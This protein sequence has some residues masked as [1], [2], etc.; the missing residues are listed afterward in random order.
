MG[1]KGH[2]QPR[3]PE[4]RTPS[5]SSALRAYLPTRMAA[6]EA[7]PS[8]PWD[9]SVPPLLTTILK[10]TDRAPLRGGELATLRIAK[11]NCAHLLKEVWWVRDGFAAKGHV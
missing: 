5:G 10:P 4:R 1:E 8:G 3:R 6:V 11:K 2:G 7:V 9:F